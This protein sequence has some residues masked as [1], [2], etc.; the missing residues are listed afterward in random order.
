MESI[1][2]FVAIELSEPL[3]ASLAAV[4]AQLKRA[5]VAHIGRWVRPELVHLTLKFLGD[6]GADRIEAIEQAITGAC[7]AVEPFSVS[8]GATGFFPD[9][10]TMRTVWVGLGGDVG[11]LARLQSSLE[12][13]LGSQGFAAEKRGFQPHLTLA[14]I[15]DQTRPEEREDLAKRVTA[16]SVDGSV[17]M[18]VREVNLIKS[19]LRPDGPAYTR[20]ACIALGRGV[21]DALSQPA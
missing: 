4:Q 13:A 3:R 15:R 16:A 8:L 9:A 11:S 7:R 19:E 20:L 6:I 2:A 17:S 1:R 21:D 10:R 5:P 14:R 18:V 12:S